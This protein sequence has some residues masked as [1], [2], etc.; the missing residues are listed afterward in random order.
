[1]KA[2]EKFDIAL[3]SWAS[4]KHNMPDDLAIELMQTLAILEVAD[5]INNLAVALTKDDEDS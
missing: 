1:M 5:A 4:G 2:R 3:D